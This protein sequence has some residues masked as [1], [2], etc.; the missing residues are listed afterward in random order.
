MI[1]LRT[2]VCSRPGMRAIWAMAVFVQKVMVFDLS[3]GEVSVLR[4][5]RIFAIQMEEE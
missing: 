2:G 5:K 3:G 4:I 1:I